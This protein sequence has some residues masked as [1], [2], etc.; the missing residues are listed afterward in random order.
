[1][2]SSVQGVVPVL[3]I[4]LWDSEWLGSAPWWLEVYFMLLVFLS[5]QSMHVPW[6][7]ACELLRSILTAWCQGT[8]QG[9]CFIEKSLGDVG[10]CNFEHLDSLSFHFGHS[11]I[12]LLVQTPEPVNFL[13]K[14]EYQSASASLPICAL[15]TAVIT[16]SHF[17]IPGV[18]CLQLLQEFIPCHRLKSWLIQTSH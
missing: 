14:Q 11:W 9:T 10:L 12:L 3:V 6:V 2:L 7:Q 18:R 8:T 13:A 16:G 1:M 17:W 15:T 4:K 5:L